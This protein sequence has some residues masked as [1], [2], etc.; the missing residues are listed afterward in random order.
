[1][2]LSYLDAV[3]NGD[4]LQ[5]QNAQNW[6]VE[7]FV[8][9]NEDASCSLIAL[10]GHAA[11]LVERSKMQGPYPSQEQA[12]AARSAI[13]AQLI[14]AGFELEQHTVPHWRLNAQRAIRELRTCRQSHTPDCTFDPKDVYLS[15]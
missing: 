1:M 10:S 8:L 7:L 3:Q 2:H 6:R 14:Q 13:A 15:D 5:L 9:E 11:G 4:A 12:L